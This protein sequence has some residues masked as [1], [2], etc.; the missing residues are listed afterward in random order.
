MDIKNSLAD[1]IL[2]VTW[3]RLIKTVIAGL[4]VISLVVVYENRQVFFNKINAGLN[5]TVDDFELKPPRLEGQKIIAGFMNGNKEVVMLSVLDANPVTNRRNVVY[6]DFNDPKIKNVV[7]R[8]VLENP[9]IGDGALFTTDP[10][11]NK[12]IL[13]ILNGE[14]FCAENKNSIIS[15]AFPEAAKQI[16][17]SCRVPLPPS[18]GKATGWITLHLNKWPLDD[19]DR[20]KSDSLL[21]SLNYYNREVLNP[22]SR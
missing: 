1:F 4:V 15:Q 16:V 19:Y 3:S 8:Y 6:R 2:N 22:H 10:I 18:F 12:Q 14:F 7:D 21:M 9:T 13:A 5:N 17:Y 11:N 20:F